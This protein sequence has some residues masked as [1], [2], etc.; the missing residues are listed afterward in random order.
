MV[1]KANLLTITLRE[2]HYPRRITNG[3]FDLVGFYNISTIVDY[4]MLN[5]VYTH[6][7]NLQTL[8]LDNIFKTGF[9]YS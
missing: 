8:I 3:Y 6:T 5:P 2:M 4:L 9:F 7:H 1:C